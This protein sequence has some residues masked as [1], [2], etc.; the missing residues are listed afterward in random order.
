MLR[1][2]PEAILVAHRMDGGRRELYVEGVRDSA[3]LGWLVGDDL[4]FKAAVVPIDMVEMPD[5]GEGGNRERLKQFL[6]QVASAGYDICGLLDADQGPLTGEEIP[7]NAWLTDFRDAEGYVMAPEN[8]SAALRLGCGIVRGSAEPLLNSM[9]E[10][11]RYLAAVRLASYRLA[12]RLPVSKSRLSGSLTATPAGMLT[13]DKT[14]YLSALLQSAKVSLLQLGTLQQA[15]EV[16]MTELLL[17]PRREVVHGKDCIRLITFQFRALGASNLQDA[18]PLL[19]SSFERER[20][21]EFPTL[22]QVVEFLT[23][24]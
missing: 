7:S 6:L 1:R 23:S 4:A 2:P 14:K 12:M 20:L 10:I 19:W 17:R 9:L 24:K 8:V 3:F 11:A 18:G 16:A 22:Q 5:V 15:I 13:L 21:S